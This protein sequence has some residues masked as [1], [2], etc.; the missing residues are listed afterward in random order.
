MS[1]GKIIR[2]RRERLGLTQNQVAAAAQISKPYLSNIE[3]GRTRNPPTERVLRMLEEAL[4]FRA[5]ELTHLADWERAPLGARQER[6]LLQA[7]VDKL[8]GIVKAFLASRPTDGGRWPADQLTA[9]IDIDAQGPEGELSAGKAVPVINK[10]SA[11]YPGDFTDLDYPPSVADE[12]VRCP[13]I[14]DPQAFAARVVGDS[15][16]PTYRQGDIVVFAPN[17]PADNGKDCF[18]RFETGQTTFKRVYQD[19]Q[20]TL[21]LQPLNDKYPAQVVSRTEVT[22]LWPAVVHISRIEQ[23]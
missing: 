1:L 14:H 19:D 16:A 7:Q 20:V 21:R 2:Q 6:D 17:T 9:Q 12:Y 23:K 13:D 18:V 11:G 3:T 10:V 15:M 4:D 22:G 5:A 8:R